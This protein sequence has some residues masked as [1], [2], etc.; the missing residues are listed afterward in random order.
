MRASM[1][2]IGN[3]FSTHRMLKEYYAGYYEAALAEIRALEADNYKAS[4]SLA[5]YLEKIWRAWQGVRIVEFSDDGSP[6]VSRGTTI[7][8]RALV[9]LAG[10]SP[11]DVAVE[12]YS[13]RLSSRGEIL[14]GGRMPMSLVGQ[15]GSYYRYQYVM[16]GEITGQVGYSVR[17]LPTHPALDGR[18]I[19]GLVRWA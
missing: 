17:I 1:R 5:R 7:T 6:V 8:V 9:D 11:D 13:G 16:H 10:L 4:I 14:D 18:F 3:R 15:E 2:V 12:C 19:P